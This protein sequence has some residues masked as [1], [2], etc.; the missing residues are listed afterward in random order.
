V[1]TSILNIFPTRGINIV[2]KNHN[3]PDYRVISK[4]KHHKK[5]PFEAFSFPFEINLFTQ[6]KEAKWGEMKDESLL[7][8]KIHEIY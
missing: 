5:T 6:K 8:T 3:T 4:F 2:T 7:S 1:W